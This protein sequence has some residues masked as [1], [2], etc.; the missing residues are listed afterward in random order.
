MKLKFQNKSSAPSFFILE[1]KGT[2]ENKLS[3]AC[4]LQSALTISKSI[5]LL[6]II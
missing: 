2:V 6:E 1:V 3:E 5:G 4:Y